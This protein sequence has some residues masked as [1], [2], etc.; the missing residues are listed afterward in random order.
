MFGTRPDRRLGIEAVN[1]G[2]PKE[3]YKGYAPCRPATILVTLAGP[4]QPTTQGRPNVR[5]RTVLLHWSNRRRSHQASARR[6]R[7]GGDP[8]P[9]QARRPGEVVVPAV[10]S[11][12]GP[13]TAG[14][15]PPAREVTARVRHPGC[16][17]RPT[18]AGAGVFRVPGVRAGAVPDRRARGTWG[19]VR[20]PVGPLR[21][22]SGKS[23]P[24][25]SHSPART[26]WRHGRLARPGGIGGGGRGAGRGRRPLLRTRILLKN[27]PGRSLSA[28]PECSRRKLGHPRSE[29]RGTGQTTEARPGSTGSISC[30]SKSCSRASW[31]CSRRNAISPAVTGRVHRMRAW[32]SGTGQRSRS[33]P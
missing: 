3:K 23:D 17:A 7:G 1:D 25:T 22:G 16:G 21:P 13:H 5:L 12:A 29:E 20:R 9:P 28:K 4:W 30:S 14:Q 31:P 32:P 24:P 10:Q 11:R 27:R 8:P 19:R 2:I 6:S 33:G 15:R 18:R 26:E